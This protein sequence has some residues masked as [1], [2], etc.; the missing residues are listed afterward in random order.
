MPKTIELNEHE[1]KALIFK[2][3][4]QRSLLPSDRSRG[5]RREYITGQDDRVLEVLTAKLR[6]L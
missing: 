4:P 3:D 1:L 5:H 2:L 6:A